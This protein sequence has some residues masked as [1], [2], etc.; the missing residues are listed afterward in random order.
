[1]HTHRGT[2]VGL[3]HTHFHEAEFKIQRRLFIQRKV[4]EYSKVHVTDTHVFISKISDR[5]DPLHLQHHNKN[6]Q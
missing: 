3:T 1:M 4:K 5:S 2:R 6:P